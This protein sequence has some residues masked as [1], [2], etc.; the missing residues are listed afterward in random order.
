MPSAHR[1]GDKRFC[2]ADTIVVGQSTV[3][4]NNKLWAV[5]GDPDTHCFEGNLKAF[6][7][8]RNVFIENKHVICAIGDQASSDKKSCNPLNKHVPPQ[9]W[10]RG[11]S[12]NVKIYETARGGRAIKIK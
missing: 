1:D 2:N 6:Y 9:T 12:P 3:F 8:P 10:P 5:E 11:K 7:G 4:V